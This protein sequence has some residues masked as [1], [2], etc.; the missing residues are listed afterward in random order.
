MPDTTNEHFVQRGANL[1]NHSSSAKGRGKWVRIGT[2]VTPSTFRTRQEAFRACAWVLALV[3]KQ[4]LPDE[5]EDL[6]FFEVLDAILPI[7]GVS[8]QTFYQNLGWTGTLEVED[9]KDPSD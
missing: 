1:P 4:E 2:T 7:E 9:D 3:E 6:S 8:E 5:D